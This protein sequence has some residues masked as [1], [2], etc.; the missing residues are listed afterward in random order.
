MSVFEE[1]AYGLENFGIPAEEIERRVVEVM[2]MTDIEA[3]AMKSPFDL[4]GS[5]LFYA[6]QE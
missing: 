5:G 6:P 3:L 1:V 4:S 2:Q